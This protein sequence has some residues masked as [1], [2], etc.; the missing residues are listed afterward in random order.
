MHDDRLSRSKRNKLLASM[1]D[2]VAELVLRN[3][4]LQS[5]AISLTGG[6]GLANGR[7]LVAS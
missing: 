4:Y 5:L 6:R 1:T 2:E 3:N 7:E